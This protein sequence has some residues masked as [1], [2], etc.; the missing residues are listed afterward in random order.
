NITM[1]RHQRL[2]FYLF[3]PSTWVTQLSQGTI[4]PE[5]SPITGWLRIIAVSA[6][7]WWGINMLINFWYSQKHKHDRKQVLYNLS[8][9]QKWVL[10]MYDPNKKT[11][12]HLP[13]DD[14]VVQS[15]VRENILVPISDYCNLAYFPL[16]LAKWVRDLYYY[17]PEGYFDSLPKNK[18]GY[19]IPYTS[20]VRA[21]CH[22]F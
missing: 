15:L 22:R 12:C 9:Q 10:A 20:D 11:I 4:A 18:Q 16:E 5:I 7:S 1:L 17:L 6:T 13:L 19:L 2:I 3:A 8:T 21:D 14:G